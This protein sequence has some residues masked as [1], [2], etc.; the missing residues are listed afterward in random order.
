MSA[1]TTVILGGGFGGIAAAN[2][3]RRLLPAEHAIT[4]IDESSRFHVGAGK[5]WIMLGERT[6]EQISQ[7][8]TALL[9]PGIRL[10]EAKAQSISLSDRT[11]STGTAS[12]KWDFL[13]I[14]LGADLN[15]A[16][17]PGLAEAA[18]TFY[19]VEGAQRLKTKLDQF[20]G[21]DVAI[22]IP[23]APFKCPPAPYEA[24]M[25]L[26]EAFRRR[27]LGGKGRLAIHT[28]EGAP[29]ATAGVEMGHYIKNEL[30]QREIGF[31]PQRLLARVDGAA[32]RL[33]FEGG[34]EARYD[35]L[36]AIP[37][38]VAPKVVR[39]AQLINQSGWIPVD[40]KTMQVKQPAEASDVYAAG[41]VTFVPLPGR[42]KPDVG[43][44]LPKAGVFA[45]AHGRIAA[46][47]IA[48]RILGRTP[49]EAFDGKGYC[50][51]ETGEKR[52]VK[53]DGSFFELPHPVMDK[54]APD[55]TQF[56]DKLDWVERLLR[57]LR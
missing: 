46:H 24:A 36:I 25:L 44:A 49:D 8:R 33:V 51:L 9:S 6:Y 50:F 4:V 23:K 21:G 30:A 56:R 16:A 32:Q 2:S 48:A 5:T 54:R 11:V 15:L 47:Q 28:I 1:K 40:P 31:F 45:E 37:P 13:V 43:L 53:T 27:G 57:P 7:I 55:E 18:H 10:V 34:S 20:S 19:T 38:H 17:V 41:D 35:L 39:D 52:A 12:L 29:M 26:H 14:A 3:L 22:V 42:Y